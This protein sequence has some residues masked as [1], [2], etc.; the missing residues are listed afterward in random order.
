MRSCHCATT[1]YPLHSYCVVG[2]ITNRQITNTRYQRDIE[3][4]RY[5]YRRVDY[6]WLSTCCESYSISWK[7]LVSRIHRPG[8]RM[9]RGYQFLSKESSKEL[10]NIE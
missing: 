5:R 8:P 6:K 3:T 10:E 9:P 2:M 4:K 7:F 1:A